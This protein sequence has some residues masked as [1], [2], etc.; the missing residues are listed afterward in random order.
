MN[1][2]IFTIISEEP[3]DILIFFGRMHPVVVHLPIG[4]LLLAALAEAVAIKPKFQPIKEF[5]HYLWGLGTISAIFAVLFGYFL[6]L[7]D[8]YNEDTLF[9]HQWMGITV[10]LLSAFYYYISRRELKLPKY[11]TSIIVTL[12]VILLIYTGHLGGNLTHGSTYLLE[13]APDPIRKLAGLPDKVKSRAKVTVLDSADVYLDLISPIMDLRC[14]S[15]HNDDKKKGDL[16]LTTYTNLIVGGENGEVVIPGD[17]DSSDLYRRIT[18]PETHDDF[19]PTDGKPPL[20]DDEVDIIRWW[21]ENMAVSNTYFVAMNPED[22]IKNKIE[23]YLELNKNLLLSKEV[24]PPDRIILDSLINHG[25]IINRLM[26]DN[27]FVEANFSISEKELSLEAIE[28]LLQLKDQIIWLNM[29]NSGVKDDQLKQIGQLHNLIKL[30][31]STNSISD[32]GLSYLYE[33]QNLESLNLYNT[34]VSN[35]LLPLVE[36]LPNLKRLYV[37]ETKTDSAIMGKLL[38]KH[39]HLRVEF[40]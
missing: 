27:Q 1:E 15:C 23:K 40:E 34:E 35:G 20:S 18:L 9:W 25:F 4:F 29:M 21:I 8:N 10:L 5:I 12:V 28:N 31:L 6:S 16:D 26:I 13:Y 7:S 19:M 38:E 17:L 36:N 30:N 2:L 33:L 37:S 32:H 3:G 14:V 24:P 22:E 39:K 11:G